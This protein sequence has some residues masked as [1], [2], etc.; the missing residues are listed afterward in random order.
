MPNILDFL[1]LAN[2]APSHAARRMTK[3]AA[4]EGLPS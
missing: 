1:L 2:A 4:H 3:H